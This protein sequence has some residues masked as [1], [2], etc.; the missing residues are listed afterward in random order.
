NCLVYVAH[1]SMQRREDAGMN[2]PNCG[3]QLR[4]P[5]FLFL[6]SSF[7]HTYS[8]SKY[9]S[10]YLWGIRVSFYTYLLIPVSSKATIGATCR[11]QKHLVEHSAVIYTITPLAQ[12]IACGATGN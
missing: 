8:T 1:A 12:P 2:V 10:N 4:S 11:I 5:A 9:Q 6:A 7:T 3:T